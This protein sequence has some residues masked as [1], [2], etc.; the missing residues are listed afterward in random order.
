[1]TASW[2][3]DLIGGPG[4]IFRPENITYSDT[5]RKFLDGS[6]FEYSRSVGS[7]YPMDKMK[8]GY[9]YWLF[10]LSDLGYSMNCGSYGGKTTSSLGDTLTGELLLEV[11]GRSEGN[12]LRFASL[13]EANDWIDDNDVLAAPEG[14][15]FNPDSDFSAKFWY[16]SPVRTGMTRSVVFN[17]PGEY[18]YSNLYITG[19]DSATIEVSSDSLDDSVLVHLIGYE[20]GWDIVNDDSF[21]VSP[22]RFRVRQ[23]DLTS[24]VS[25]PWVYTSQYK[26][27]YWLLD[28]VILPQQ[29][30]EQ[31]Y[32]GVGEDYMFLTTPLAMDEDGVAYL[33]ISGGGK[34]YPYYDHFNLVAIDIPAKGN[35]IPALCGDKLSVFDGD[36]A[37][38][39]KLVVD[40]NGDTITEVLQNDDDWT[41]VDT[42][43]GSIEIWVD[44]SL[45][46][47]GHL[48]LVFSP[49]PAPKGGNYSEI[50]VSY[51][52]YTKKNWVK[53][54]SVLGRIERFPVVEDVYYTSSGEDLRV[55]LEWNR[56]IRFDGI[57]VF[58]SAVDTA[59]TVK[60]ELISA[61]HS[62]YGDM[63]GGLKWKGSLVGVFAGDDLVLGYK[64]SDKVP[65]DYVRYWVLESA[66]DSGV[67]GSD[68]FWA[69]IDTGA[70]EVVIYRRGS[71]T[72]IESA[73][74]CIDDG[75]TGVCGYTNASGVY[76][77]PIDL[78]YT[79]DIYVSKFGFRPLKVQHVDYISGN[80]VWVYDVELLGDAFVG[81]GDTLIISAGTQ[82]R[83][84]SN[85]DISTNQDD[86]NDNRVEI[87]VKGGHIEVEGT[88]DNPVVLAPKPGSSYTFQ[89]EGVYCRDGGTANIEN[90]IFKKSYMAVLGNNQ[91]GRITVKDS[92]IEDLGLIFINYSQVDSADRVFLAESCY[93]GNRVDVKYCG[94]SCVVRACTLN[95]GYYEG[96]TIQSS[97]YGM[98][99]Y[100]NCHIEGNRWRC[101]RLLNYGSAEF[102][103]CEF[104]GHRL[105]TSQQY[106]YVTSNAALYLDNSRVDASDG[107]TIN[108]G[109][110]DFG[111]T[112]FIKS[113]WTTFDHYNTCVQTDNSA[114]FGTLSD[115]GHNC[116]LDDDGYVIVNDG[117]D[118]IPAEWNYYDTLLFKGSVEHD[119]VDTVC[120]PDSTLR[121]RIVEDNKPTL[122]KGFA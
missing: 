109:I 72:V 2:G 31:K 90:A 98:P 39:L 37:L 27:D 23:I 80:E 61:S 9:G 25:G 55:K 114:D 10:A 119:S 103:D 45:Y 81:A 111:D 13:K 6:L 86:F 41:Y 5:T 104:D 63:K 49:P 20:R 93:V 8:P 12:I 38:P 18:D 68:S 91:P 88:D 16:E 32:A 29:Y 78:D 77:S 99:R 46:T 40:D 120:H 110:K 117:S 33:K 94:D 22:G 116:F 1:I 76:Y 11:R 7:Y 113:R 75:D 65:K 26:D 62:R 83:T 64:V 121:R 34:S 4:C 84:A 24:A 48:Y 19:S 97:E 87:V 57:Y 14:P 66:G 28:N 69:K 56:G 96:A 42:G 15:W 82:V 17:L 59:E 108:Y 107:R 105:Y 71:S 85:S 3:W 53:T 118:T 60:T 21:G 44:E 89:W 92:R 43:S 54:G 106:F 51:Y 115:P 67:V 58:R 102:K 36:S 95:G 30:L 35:F 52:D 101:V 79:Q 100:E 73:W 74:V 122:P 70:N 47:S 50:V 112:I